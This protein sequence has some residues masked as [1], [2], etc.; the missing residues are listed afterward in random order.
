[1]ALDKPE[2]EL[3]LR[4]KRALLVAQGSNPAT[5]GDAMLPLE[6]DGDDCFYKCPHCG[7]K[8]VVVDGRNIYGMPEV[9]ISHLKK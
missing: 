8:N 9:R 7:A 3:C 2:Q 5:R 1:M 4:C 6:S